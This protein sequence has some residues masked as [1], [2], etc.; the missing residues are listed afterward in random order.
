MW[1]RGEGGSCDDDIRSGQQGGAP[2]LRWRGRPVC[3][4]MCAYVC[5]RAENCRQ[6][7]QD[8]QA[9]RTDTHARHTQD[10]PL[11]DL[12][13]GLHVMEGAHDMEVDVANGLLPTASKVLKQRLRCGKR[14][15]RHPPRSWPCVGVHIRQHTGIYVHL[16]QDANAR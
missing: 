9:E 8:G 15:M 13:A 16:F 7:R 4:R 3:V 2:G 10:T 14:H 1:R 12:H 6:A 5:A 11:E